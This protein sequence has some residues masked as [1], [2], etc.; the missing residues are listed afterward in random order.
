MR[1]W[2]VQHRLSSVNYPQSNGRAELGVK[3]ARR[4]I[5]DNTNPDGSINNDQAARAILQYRNTPLRDVGLSPAQLLLHRQLRDSI[6][7]NPKLL[8]PHRDWLISAEE[9]ENALAQRNK[10]IEDRYNAHAHD[11]EPLQVQ[12]N[13]RIQENKRWLKTGQIIEV[14]P[15]RQYLIKMDGSGR[16]TRRNRRFIKQTDKSETS[17]IIISPQ[18]RN[19]PNESSNQE[20]PSP[21]TQSQHPEPT[22]TP[23]PP[24][25]IPTAQT[26]ESPQTQ[27]PEPTQPPQTPPSSRNQSRQTKIPRLVKEIK[28]YNKAGNTETTGRRN[29][30][31]RGGKDF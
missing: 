6:P 19:G 12:T 15:N 9:R 24:S 4:I 27:H 22:Q 25:H 17:N 31:L 11:L 28:S 2:G 10:Y 21:Q 7:A 1:D 26:P 18:Y 8:R 13:V 29:S 23:P 3:A 14:L 16:I 5:R 30:R 20:V